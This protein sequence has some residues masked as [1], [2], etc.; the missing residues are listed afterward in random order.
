VLDCLV[1]AGARVSFNP[2]VQCWSGADDGRM[3]LA[4]G[5]S[6]TL[7]VTPILRGCDQ[8]HLSNIAD[9]MDGHLVSMAVLRRDLVGDGAKRPDTRGMLTCGRMNCSLRSEP[10]ATNPGTHEPTAPWLRG[11]SR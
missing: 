3:C 4:R 1:C 5:R 7:P 10:S 11:P 8:W 6:Y 9:T 2:S